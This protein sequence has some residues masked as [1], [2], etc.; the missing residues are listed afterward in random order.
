M[1]TD[2]TQLIGKQVNKQRECASLT[3]I[4]TCHLVIL[5]SQ[6]YEIDMNL[7]YLQVS[8]SSTSLLG[9]SAQ[10][11]TYSWIS[12]IDLLYAMMLP[13]GN[14][15]AF[16]LAENYATLIQIG[17]LAITKNTLNYQTCFSSN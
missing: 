1:T 15:S 12:I 3:K 14:D 4:M 7:T 11:Q 13:S 16:C 8:P 5:L 6:K 17:H 10:I 9:T 2:G